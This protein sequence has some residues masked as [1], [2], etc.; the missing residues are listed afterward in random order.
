MLEALWQAL[1]T[2]PLESR[3]TS[4][5]VFSRKC[6]LQFCAPKVHIR[7]LLLLLLLL[8]VGMGDLHILQQC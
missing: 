4:L 6:L 8:L 5:V 3:I 2:Q 7:K 1:R